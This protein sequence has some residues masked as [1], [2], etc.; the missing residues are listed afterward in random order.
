MTYNKHLNTTDLE[1]LL[2]ASFEDKKLDQSEKH[3]FLSLIAHTKIDQRRFL[4]N[5]AY[6]LVESFSRQSDTN[7]TEMIV[8]LKWLEKIS[9]AIDHFDLHKASNVFFSPG[10]ESR[11]AIISACEK[12]HKTIDICVFTLSDNIITRAIKD[13]YK[14]NVNIRVISDNDK[15]FDKG[16]D[17]DE[18]QHAGIPIR[19]D[20]TSNHMH[21]KFAIFDKTVLINGSFNWT[22][23]ATE[24]NEENIVQHFDP[25]LINIFSIKFEDLWNKFDT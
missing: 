22:R 1:Q 23:S 19:L 11:K 17:I 16:S 8:A 12:S 6:D 18:L 7:K 3:S 4:K 9:K 2:I 20:K 14:R 5:R 25:K 13:A 10:E 24:R 15:R 21:H